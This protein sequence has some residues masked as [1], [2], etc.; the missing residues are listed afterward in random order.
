MQL[1]RNPAIQKSLESSLSTALLI[2]KLIIPLYILADILLYFD[3]LSHV[4]F[5]FTPITSFLGLPSEAAMAIGAGVLLN[6]YAGIAFAA[7]LGLTPYQWTILAVF[8]GVCHSMIVETAI[9]KRL[10]ISYTYSIILRVVAAFVTVL[11]VMMMPESFFGT[12]KQGTAVLKQYDSFMVMLV[13]SFTDSLILSIKIIG[14]IALVIFFMDWLKSTRLMKEYA[15][16][17]NASF[18]IIVGLLLGIIYGAGILVRE[19][20]AGHLTRKDV[21]FISTF[22]MICHSIIEDGL[23]FVIFGA[24]YW[25]IIGVRLAAAFIFSFFFLYLFT[26]VLP[27]PVVKEDKA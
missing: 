15:S 18:S 1:S 17:V 2:I 21:L 26:T 25:V 27:M 12:V 9:M 22:L 8:L 16:K 10:G 4:T 3:L 6:L 24:N 13:G 23:L 14:L 11:P 19:V 7:P 5:L 20:D